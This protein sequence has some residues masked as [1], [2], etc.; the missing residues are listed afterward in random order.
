MS[1]LVRS[2]SGRR[3]LGRPA[4]DE[5]A[6]RRDPGANEHVEYRP[7]DPGEINDE[8][9]VAWQLCQE[10]TDMGDDGG[11]RHTERQALE[12]P[13]LKNRRRRSCHWMNLSKSLTRASS[14]ISE[15][16]AE[17]SASM[18]SPSNS[19]ANSIGPSFC[20]ILSR[21]LHRSADIRGR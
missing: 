14:I 16:K 9:R 19:C 11:V 15:E 13:D 2:R 18:N 10:P 5:H 4:A 3:A 6:N 21:N 8:L 1:A 7:S 12:M 17:L 20:R